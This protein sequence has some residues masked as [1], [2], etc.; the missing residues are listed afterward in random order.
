MGLLSYNILKNVP[1]CPERQAYCHIKRC[2]MSC[3]I[4]YM[5]KK[6]RLNVLHTL[7]SV[8]WHTYSKNVT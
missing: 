6:T 7:K 1:T 5:R 3:A 4:G 2:V 8:T